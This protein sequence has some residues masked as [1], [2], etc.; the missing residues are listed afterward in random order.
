MLRAAF[1]TQKLLFL[2]MHPFGSDDAAAKWF[3]GK[4]LNG[5]HDYGIDWSPADPVAESVRK[6]PQLFSRRRVGQLAATYRTVVQQEGWDALDYWKV[7]QAMDEGKF[8]RPGDS[9]HPADPSIAVILDWALEK[10]YRWETYGWVLGRATK[11]RVFEGHR[12][13]N[14]QGIGRAASFEVT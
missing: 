9:I 5:G 14:S 7:S 6:L 12:L 10:L 8:I 11:P 13:M 1:P 2:Q 3:W 4:A